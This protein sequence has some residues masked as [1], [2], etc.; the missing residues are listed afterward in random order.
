M[1]IFVTGASGF[2]GRET[3]L[4]AIRR[5]HKVVAIGGSRLPE[6]LG[7]AHALNL[8]LSNPQNLERLLLDEFPDAVI[9]CAAAS[10]LEAC[11]ANP[12]LAKALNTDLPAFLATV[13]NHLSARLVHVSSDMVFDGKKPSYLHTDMPAPLHVYGATKFDGEKEVLKNGKSCAVT[14]RVSPLSGNSV[15]G[16][17]GLHERLMV[18]WARGEV[19]PLFTDEIRQPVS[20]SNLADVLVE[21]C[22]RGNLSGVYHWAG[23]EALSRYE[24]GRRIAEYFGFKPE[25][26]VSPAVRGEESLGR[27]KELRLDLHPLQ[28]KLRTRAQNFEEILSELRVPEHLE[29]WH[30]S[31][32]G[33][34]APVR[35]LVK[36]VDF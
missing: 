32:T 12:T 30:T 22:E 13:A 8:D 29:V 19:T 3:V 6:I 28:G 18:R 20:V 26:V 23:T 5:G 27:P 10:T 25:S 34:P 16:Y 1:K 24:I 36:G 35:R 11:A 21:L 15:S 31:K 33:R 17:R 9:N 2:L 14:L 4:S 7:V